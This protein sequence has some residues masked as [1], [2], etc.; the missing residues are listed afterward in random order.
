MAKLVTSQ[1]KIKLSSLQEIFQA[2]THHDV[3]E[4]CHALL[5][6]QLSLH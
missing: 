4:K 1:K 5:A 6:K 3:I 2:D